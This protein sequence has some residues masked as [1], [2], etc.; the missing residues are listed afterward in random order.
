MEIAMTTTEMM[1]HAARESAADRFLSLAGAAAGRVAALWRAYQNR[2][3][4]AKLLYWDSRMLGDIGLTA[5]DIDSAMAAPVT[6]DP[7]ARLEALSTE[8]RAGLKAAAREQL[9][10]AATP[11]ARES[12]R[13]LTVIET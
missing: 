9:R 6:E 11:Q 4:V 5:G 8:R 2:R 7:S 10:F 3:A 13:H 12:R 1:P